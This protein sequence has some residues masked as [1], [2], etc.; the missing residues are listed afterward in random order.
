[1]W[2]IYLCPACSL[3]WKLT[4]HERIAPG[5]LPPGRLARYE[6]NDADLAHAVGLDSALLRRAGVRPGP[7]ELSVSGPDADAVLAPDRAAARIQ[8]V[9]A[10]RLR[11]DRLLARQ[12]SAS[13][14]ELAAW[15]RA[16]WLRLEPPRPRALRRPARDGQRILIEGA[17]I[18]ADRRRADQSA[19]SIVTSVYS[20]ESPGPAV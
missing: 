4:V 13:R 3:S 5:S 7:V 20:T 1:M 12:L 8:L 10:A 14:A 2:S 15:W 11:L 6:R 9:G 18:R 17:A 16:G 19:A